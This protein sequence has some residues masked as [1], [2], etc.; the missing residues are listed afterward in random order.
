MGGCTEVV[1]ST[2][3]RNG[4]QIPVVDRESYIFIRSYVTIEMLLPLSSGGPEDCEPNPWSLLTGCH[5]IT[6]PPPGQIHSLAKT[7][8]CFTCRL[9]LQ[10]P[11]TAIGPTH[12]PSLSPL[13]RLYP[14]W[15]GPFS[16]PSH[17]ICS[18]S[19]IHQSCHA[20]YSYRQLGTLSSTS[21][22]Y[23]VTLPTSPVSPFRR[24]RHANHPI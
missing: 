12:T 5:R 9:L 1:R 8:P 20:I 10:L 14:H 15:H 6:K 18:Q 17:P 7:P 21:A 19:L 11:T 3:T 22:C 2:A 23:P 16:V 4:R 24:L 13:I